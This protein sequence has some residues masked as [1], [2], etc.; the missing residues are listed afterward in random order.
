MRL[1]LIS[2]RIYHRIGCMHGIRRLLRV[3]NQERV[4]VNKRGTV[5]K[6]AYVIRWMNGSDIGLFGMFRF[7]ICHLKY[8]DENGWIPVIDWKNFDNAYLLSEEVGTD[9]AWNFYFRDPC[10]YSLDDLIM[11]KRIVVSSDETP[12]NW[13]YVNSI[14]TRAIVAKYI[15]FSNDVRERIGIEQKK[16]K[17]KFGENCRILGVK[18]RGTDYITTKP[19][20]HSV[21]PTIQQVIKIIRDRMKEWGDFDVCFLATE[22]LSIIQK[23]IE[24]F[25]NW[26]YVLKDVDRFLP[27]EVWHESRDSSRCPRKMGEDYCVEVGLLAKCNSLIASGSQGTTGALLLNQDR[28]EQYYKIDLGVYER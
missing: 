12:N 21:Q 27:T 24:A 11:F 23:M 15:F 22:D 7:V 4:I 3:E 16:I 6:T 19:Y 17:D 1:Y 13:P 5:D 18:L 8:A 20:L 25:G 2:G 14:Q 10:G 9:N 28:Y 26:I